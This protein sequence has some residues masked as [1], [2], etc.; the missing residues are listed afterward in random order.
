MRAELPREIRALAFF[1]LNLSE[2]YAIAQHGGSSLGLVG[3]FL[4]LRFVPSHFLPCPLSEDIRARSQWSHEVACTLIHH[5]GVSSRFICP[6][7]ALPTNYGILPEGFMP[8]AQARRNLTLIAKVLQ[9]I[10]WVPLLTSFC[11]SCD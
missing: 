8:S 9:V 7:I 5:H 6:A 11:C 2:K 4:L 3:G 1:I 10:F